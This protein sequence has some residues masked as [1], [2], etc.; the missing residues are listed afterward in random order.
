MVPDYFPIISLISPHGEEVDEYPQIEALCDELSRQDLR[1]GRVNLPVHSPDCKKT[2][3]LLT[4]ENLKNDLLFVSGYCQPGWARLYLGPQDVLLPAASASAQPSFF[5]RH[6]SDVAGCAERLV[7]WLG[8]CMERTEL[9]GCI[10]IGG[11]SSRMGTPKHLLDAGNGR[12]WLEQ[13]VERLSSQVRKIVLSGEG[14]VPQSLSSLTRIDDLSGLSGPMSGIAA[15]I[16]AYPHVC[17]IVMACDMPDFTVESIRWI[18]KQR[19]PGRLA[20]I[21]RN[22]ITNR[23]EPLYG[24]YDYRSVRLFDQL[25]VFGDVRMN[26]LGTLNGVYQPLIPDRLLGAWRNVNRPE[27]LGR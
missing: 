6:V 11:K 18:M 2:R 13:S 4:R 20:V 23:G 19:K 15:A 17:W 27:D 22:P 8:T 7:T 14:E 24:W 10:L 9:W 1:I 12:S 26:S 5:C 3:E 21:P 16:R 25:S